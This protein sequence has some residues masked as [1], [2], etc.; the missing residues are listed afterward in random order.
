[1]KNYWRFYIEKPCTVKDEV[2]ALLL[3]KRE[4][5][6]IGP[7]WPHGTF[8]GGMAIKVESGCMTTIGFDNLRKSYKRISRKQALELNPKLVSHCN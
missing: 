1:M 6:Y 4:D 2:I 7:V 8:T 5:G 3:Q